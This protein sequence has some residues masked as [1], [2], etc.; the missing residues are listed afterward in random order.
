MKIFGLNITRDIPRHDHICHCGGE[1]AAHQ[2]GTGHCLRYMT[3]P[4]KQAPYGRW[5]VEGDETITDFTLRQQRGYHQHPCG[6]WSR[7]IGSE[8]SIAA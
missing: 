8:N 2:T 5:I 4:P 7:S 3:I 1:A 6:C